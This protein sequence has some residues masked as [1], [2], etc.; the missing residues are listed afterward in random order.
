MSVTAC[1]GCAV[2]GA[3]QLA[4]PERVTHEL[5]LPGIHCAGCIRGVERALARCPDI[6]GARVNLTRKRVAVAARSGADP[7]PW[8]RELAK[9]GY[10]AHEVADAAPARAAG[11]DYTIHMGVAGF[12]MMNVT[13][14]SVAVWAGAGDTTRDFLHWVSAAI[15][16][17]AAAF[18]AQPFFRSAARALLARRVNMDVPISLAIV[19]ACAMSLYEVV[20]SGQH[21]WFD[22]AL[23]L[24]F[25]LLV[26]RVLDQRLRRAAH[27]A[28]D[29]LAAMEPSRVLRIEDGV[30]VSR[31]LSEIAVG[32]ALWLT[33]GARVP[34]E[35]RL[36]SAETMVDA[37]FIT[38][39]SD[40]VQRSAGAPLRAG[41]IVLNG[42]V[43]LRATAVGEDTTIRRIA[44][45]V[46]TAEGAR[47]QYIGVADRAA[48]IYTPLV[49]VLSAAAFIGW[50]FATGDARMAINVAIAT[51]IITCPCALG[52]AV[53]AVAVAATARLYRA[54]LLIKSDTAL[55]RFAAVDTVVFD[56]TGT[57]TERQLEVPAGLRDADRRILRALA[58]ASDHPLCRTLSRALS[59]VTPAPLTDLRETAG[60]GVS[61]R[62]GARVVA[63]GREDE[64]G[65]ETVFRIGETTHVLA[66][67]EALLPSARDAVRALREAGLR[68]V[69]LTGD[70]AANAAR[71][72]AALS[73]DEVH[74][75]LGP[76]DKLAILRDLEA[77]GAKV[78]MVGDG[79]NDTAALAAAYASMAPGTA[80]DASRKAADAILV[81]KDLA[82]IADALAVSRRATRRMA[83]NINISTLYNLV[84]VPI[85]IAGFATPL[86]ASIAM[87]S[88][89]I[90][91]VLNAI[92]GLA[93]PRA[94]S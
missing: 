92:R 84:A 3:A 72:A 76:E 60:Q 62:F 1:P 54:G 89:S 16:L 39:E 93:P 30:R 8:I 50:Y 40:P 35:A 15:A 55:E 66:A 86:A 17:P 6:D 82:G 31:L 91:V 87:S 59:E 85:A 78:L 41:E 88:S 47:G 27:S 73:L 12:A 28:A 90:T 75:R 46:A 13:L 10:E 48:E 14:L 21:A 61:A 38:G 80:L 33:A 71:M 22:A 18:S 20:H 36:E 2:E 43:I 68:V 94:K 32:D 7:T 81:S 52:L 70:S 45:L 44:Q 58:D 42:P 69:M 65:A 57:L 74:A 53:P 9:A 24:T 23:T 56:K 37:S 83:Q 64:A 11:E 79:L 67:K 34:V 26:G 77:E 49:H 63:L 25:F 5:V 29:N 51:L 19:L 4:A